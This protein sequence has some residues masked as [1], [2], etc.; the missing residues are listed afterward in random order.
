[1]NANALS[2]LGMLFHDEELSEEDLSRC[3]KKLAPE[4]IDLIRMEYASD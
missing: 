2:N 1:M 3:L 4:T